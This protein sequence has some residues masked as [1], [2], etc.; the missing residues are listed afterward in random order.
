MDISSL[1]WLAILVAAL[2]NFLIGGLWYSPI[3]FGKQWM[4]ENKFTDEDMKKGNM[5]K[6]FGLTFLFSFVMAFNLAMFLNDSN[7]TVSWGAI[8][9]FLTGFGW[10]AMAI[11]II[12]LFERKTIKYMVINAGYMIVSFTLMGLILGAW[13]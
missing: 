6:I 9:G 4:K 1:N 8:A 3:L 13:R 7:T 2:S 12:G 5:A 10:V 11:F